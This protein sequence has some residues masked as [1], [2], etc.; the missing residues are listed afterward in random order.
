MII[1]NLL[2]V[3]NSK[4]EF[5]D[6]TTRYGYLTANDINKDMLYVISPF[7]YST[8]IRATFKNYEQGEQG[9]TVFFKKSKK[10]IEDLIDKDNKTTP[11]ELVKDWNVW[12]SIMP[13]KA[14]TYV[15]GN[16][17]GDIE[18]SFSFR[19][20]IPPSIPNGLEYQG[21]IYS[22]DNIGGYGAYLVKT[23]LL[24]LDEGVFANYNDLIIYEG[25]FSLIRAII[26]K[27]GTAPITYEVDP[28]IKDEDYEIVE[29]DL[30]SSLI[31]MVGDVADDVQ[32]L[33]N[34]INN[35]LNKNIEQDGRLD[36]NEAELIR[37]D[38][39]IDDIDVESG[40]VY[41]VITNLDVENETTEPKVVTG[42]FIKNLEIDGGT[43]I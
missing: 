36:V 22:L 16:R 37:L 6:G 43:F 15:A 35:I 39:R 40:R 38:G 4:L 14:L 33:D 17:G 27:G 2:F 19:E 1:N 3:I 8:D 24:E 31:S 5:V 20:H 41:D 12:Q 7:P 25:T 42:E 18:V 32:G 13:N 30:V 9:E 28:N 10:K 29:F 34:E 23:N 21:E 26:Q 11:Y